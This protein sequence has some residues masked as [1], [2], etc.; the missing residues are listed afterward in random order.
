MAFCWLLAVI[1]LL[2]SV[3]SASNLLEPSARQRAFDR[4]KVP[5]SAI[6]TDGSWRPMLSFRQS[7]GTCPPYSAGLG[8]ATFP[9][10]MKAGDGIV[11]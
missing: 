5:R 3:F 10:L 2:S 4:L 9:L 1:M 7:Q 6:M 11:K 8:A